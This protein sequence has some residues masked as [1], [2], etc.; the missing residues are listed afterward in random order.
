MLIVKL[1]KSDCM[2]SRKPTRMEVVFDYKNNEVPHTKRLNEYL[3][4]AI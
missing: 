3:S 2:P 1:E 4:D